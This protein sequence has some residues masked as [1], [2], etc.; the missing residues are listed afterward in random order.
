MAYLPDG[1]DSAREGSCA[2]QCPACPTPEDWEGT[3]QRGAPNL[4]SNSYED[5]WCVVTITSS[6]IIA[7]M[8]LIRGQN[9]RSISCSM[10]ISGW[11]ANSGQRSSTSLSAQ[12][13]RIMLTMLF[14]EFLVKIGDRYEE[15][16]VCIV[17]SENAINIIFQPRHLYIVTQSCMP[18]TMQTF[19]AARNISQ[20]DQFL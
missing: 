11:K 4:A 19:V 7:Y 9:R 10:P 14:K 5:S 17:K 18:S 12:D 1:V 13:S 8:L 3:G 15:A 16:E 2:I 20:V 6:F